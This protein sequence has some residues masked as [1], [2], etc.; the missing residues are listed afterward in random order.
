MNQM[1]STL[2]EIIWSCG[3]FSLFLRRL[4]YPPNGRNLSSKFDNLSISDAADST[5]L[6]VQRISS[7]GRSSM[8]YSMPE[9][10]LSCTAHAMTGKL[11]WKAL[12]Q[13]IVN[14]YISRFK[15]KIRGAG[16]FLLCLT[17]V[18]VGETNP[19]GI[20]NRYLINPN[21]TCPKVTNEN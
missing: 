17:S 5:I 7:Q 14:K 9:F 19:A 3:G 6:D 21:L 4:G 11:H 13:Y 16:S 12:K 8:G 1:D 18:G 20:P 15:K 10:I 2:Q